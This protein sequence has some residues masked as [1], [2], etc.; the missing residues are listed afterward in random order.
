MS[1]IRFCYIMFIIIWLSLILVVPP[2]APQPARP[3]VRLTDPKYALDPA[4]ADAA[5]LAA[6]AD[7]RAGYE[8]V[9]P[10]GRLVVTRGWPIPDGVTV[11]GAGQNK[12]F[13]ALKPGLP[14]RTNQVTQTAMFRGA[15]Q[16]TVKNLT[17]RDFSIE[18]YSR[19]NTETDSDVAPMLGGIWLINSTNCTVRRVTVRDPQLFGIQ[20]VVS[21]GQSSTRLTVADC[22]VY[23]R[24]A[25]PISTTISVVGI[26]A[27]GDIGP[28]QNGMA[29]F[30]SRDNPSYVTSRFNEIRFLGNYIEG[31]THAI[32][33]TNMTRFRMEGNHTVNNVHRGLIF[34]ANCAHGVVENNRV[35]TAGSTGIHF[36]YGN[37]DILIRGNYVSGTVGQEGDG[38]K[39]YVNNS[40]L[41]I[42]RNT[43]VDAP[44]AGIR[45]AHGAYACTI[46]NN[47]VLRR[48]V[49]QAG[50]SGISVVANA[51]I[52][53]RT[54]LTFGGQLRAT[55]NRVTEN[56][57]DGVEVGI[58]LGDDQQFRNSVTRN[59][60]SANR[61]SHCRIG[62]GNADSTALRS[63]TGNQLTGNVLNQNGINVAR[64]LRVGN[65]F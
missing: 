65:S 13:I 56:T 27:Y 39:A 19:G 7:L 14:A 23:N 34:S 41:T 64:P 24:L 21:K 62:I 61:I 53:Y 30:M 3:V 43:V 48:A 36:C 26:A 63:V 55:D 28:D 42:E 59:R 49:P 18:L 47:R 11:R 46:R 45:V 54:G 40:R 9:L 52:Q 29:K 12:T 15:D 58:K 17:F 10:A 31:G 60:V 6:I 25:M 8:F 1:A 20:A 4:N 33:G 16:T 22:R 35:E 32:V 5:M 44:G 38:I 51:G 50:T 37:E 2:T 57:V